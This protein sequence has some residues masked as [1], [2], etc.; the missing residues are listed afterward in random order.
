MKT[1]LLVVLFA[2]LYCS[3]AFAQDAG[4]TNGADAG[5]VEKLAGDVKEVVDPENP[6]DANTKPLG[7]AEPEITKTEADELVDEI[8]DLL[9]E[10]TRLGKKAAELDEEKRTRIFDEIVDLRNDMHSLMVRVA[11]LAKED[12]RIQKRLRPILRRES[13]LIRDSIRLIQRENRRLIKE[14]RRT[15][16]PKESIILEGLLTERKERSVHLLG[17]NFAIL[18]FREKTGSNMSKE[19]EKLDELLKKEADG[20]VE[21]LTAV[22]KRIRE[23]QAE[24]PLAGEETAH[25]RLLKILGHRIEAETDALQ[26]VTEIMEKR[27]LETVDYRRAILENSGEIT[28]DIFDSNVLARLVEKWTASTRRWMVEQ[29]PKLVMK[30]IVFL[31]ILL[32]TFFVQKG[33]RRLVSRSLKP[34]AL[35]VL[36]KDFVRTS[37]ARGVWLIGIMFALAQFDVDMGA[38]LAG[39][40]IAGFIIGFALQDTL[41]NFASGMMILIYRPY[42]VGD[43]IDVAGA[44]GKV[45]HMSMVSTNIT[46][47][48]N[49]RLVVPNNKVWQDVI[50]NVTAARQRRVDL[51]F[52]IG[53]DDDFVKAEKV[54]EQVIADCDMIMTG[55]ANPDFAP[56][57]KLHN[58][59]DSSVDIVVRAW[60]TTD[61][62]WDV[63]WIL[64]REVKRRFDEEGITIP[65]PQR[66]L[67]LVSSPWHHPPQRE[68][69]TP[70]PS[71]A[72]PEIGT[73]KAPDEPPEDDAEAK[74]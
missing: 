57:V 7:E 35:S 69:D 24:G 39:L 4:N 70:E 38:F 49:Q 67:H 21:Q 46:T 11:P 54:I 41:S 65:Y 14:L 63:Y 58:L 59:G 32:V 66:D 51:M 40:G 10:I 17:A 9:N 68:D 55:E 26:D 52:G 13:K 73:A 19:F 48:D 62:Y 22:K 71:S 53:Y 50:R 15:P 72:G 33:V 47:L 34:T 74:T 37:A 61:N 31:L 30:T 44:F 23:L 64:M 3:P 12:E 8:G 36:A 6:L 60:T 16:D 42:D 45:T 27:E 20:S 25:K 5:L 29:G 2:L 18:T 56:T 43:L 1:K 28:T